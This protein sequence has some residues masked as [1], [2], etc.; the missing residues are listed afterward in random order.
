[1]YSYSMIEQADKSEAREKILSTASDLFYRQGYQATGINQIIDQSG[2]AKATFYSHF[3]SKEDLC[4]A[5]M[6]RVREQETQS[7]HAELAKR[8][9]ALK[10]YMALF[11]LMEP[12]LRQTDFKG[13][14]FLNMVPEIIDPHH[15][16]RKVGKDFYSDCQRIMESLVDE[17]IDTDRG[18]YEH[19]K[20]DRVARDYMI[21]FA[22]SISLCEIFHGIEPLHHG[23]SMVRELLR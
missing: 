4:L 13:C 7:L 16:I 10:R 1:M 21:I 20:P 6:Q 12:W 18:K 22:G 8:K 2:V 3:P 14:A 15:P 19:L 17:L 5:Y 9:G 23:M 11:E